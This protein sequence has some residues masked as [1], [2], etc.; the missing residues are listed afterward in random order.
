M[1]QTTVPLHEVALIAG[2]RA[3]FGFGLGLLLSSRIPEKHRSAI[4]WTLLGVGAL[5]TVPL[6]YDVLSRS[7]SVPEVDWAE[8]PPAWRL[9]R[10]E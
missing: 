7:Q 2:T 9:T 3:A 5:S 1:R 8:N 6:L 10:P 4:G